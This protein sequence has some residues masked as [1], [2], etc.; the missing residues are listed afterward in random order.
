VQLLLNS[1]RGN[2]DGCKTDQKSITQITF[3]L[4]SC[5]NCHH[6]IMGQDRRG[7]DRMVDGFKVFGSPGINLYPHE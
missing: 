7:R 2:G 4:C 6:I 1:N 5:S 3:I